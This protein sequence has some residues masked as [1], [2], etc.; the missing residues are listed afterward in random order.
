MPCLALHCQMNKEARK[1][2]AL[3]RDRLPEVM[4]S[5]HFALRV[6][7]SCL[8]AV[9]ARQVL[10]VLLKRHGDHKKETFVDFPV[11]G[12]DVAPYCAKVR[13]CL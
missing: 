2:I 6:H 3:W 9:C 1:T 12:L 8:P 11:N 10:I 7:T 5:R 13:G 4:S